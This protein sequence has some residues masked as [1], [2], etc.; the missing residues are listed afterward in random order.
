MH[1]TQVAY[2][3]HGCRCDVCATAHRRRCKAYRARSLAAGGSTTVDATPTAALLAA[4]AERMSMSSIGRRLGTSHS[5]VGK[6]IRGEIERISPA[7]AAQV[8]R[9]LPGHTP[10]DSSHVTA[11]GTIRRLQALHAIGYTWPRLA[12]ETGI[13]LTGIKSIVY[14]KW[15]VI[16]GGTADR[17]RSAYERLAMRVPTSENRHVKGA[18]TSAR[19]ASQRKGWPTPLAWDDIDTDPEPQLTGDLGTCITDGCSNRAERRDWCLF[20]YKRLAQSGVFHDTDLLDA[21]GV[22]EVVVQRILDRIP[23]PDATPAERGEAAARWLDSGR[24]YNEF[25]RLTGWKLDRVIR[26]RRTEVA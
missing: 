12:T 17:V 18:I 2:S 3:K 15:T 25:E 6:V 14:G 23:Q 8:S 26:S 20:H 16:E 21:D 19:I 11:I 9:E 13:S 22:D 1:G 10:T 4:A 24:G 5:W 7:R